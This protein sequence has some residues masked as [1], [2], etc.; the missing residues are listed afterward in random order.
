[1]ELD[2]SPDDKQEDPIYTAV[3]YSRTLYCSDQNDPLHG[4]PYFGQSVR[5]TETPEKAAKLRWQAEDNQAIRE[6]KPVGLIA[7]LYVHGPSA[8]SNEIKEWKRGPRTIVK[9]WADEREMHWIAHF[10]GPMRDP[11]KKLRQTLNILEGGSSSNF[12]YQDAF[13]S[14][15]W[16]KFK[17]ELKEYIDCNGTSL[18]PQVYVSP[19]NFR[20]GEQLSNVRQG[21]LWKGHL[22][23]AEMVSWLEALPHW[24]W[25]LQE[26]R[27]LVAWETFKSELVRYVESFGTALVPQK[28]VSP[29][30]HK[31]GITLETVRHAGNYINDDDGETRRSF[32]ESLPGWS[33]NAKETE[34]WKKK[35][36][37]CCT[38]TIDAWNAR[39]TPEDYKRI[40]RKRAKT[41]HDAHELKMKTMTDDEKRKFQ[42]KKDHSQKMARR[43]QQQLD[44]LR[45]VQGY[46]RATIRDIPKARN[47]GILPSID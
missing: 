41:I 16:S 22:F 26:T 43:R 40:Q 18:V 34:E 11:T 35:Q 47:L 38:A 13:R 15:C 29:S 10:G 31:L 30:G 36:L 42:K 24:T 33:W 46:E 2:R 25:N 19:S 37:E 45:K 32:L 27:R 9:K 4:I 17:H 6:T 20:L 8:F 5:A 39:A 1:M 28:Y 3:V 12:V 23:E 7:M 14:I 44:A 21:K